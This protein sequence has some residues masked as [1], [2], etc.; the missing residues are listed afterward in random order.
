MLKKTRVQLKKKR[1]DKTRN[2][3]TK[4]KSTS[5]LPITKRK[6]RICRWERSVFQESLKL[7]RQGGTRGGKWSSQEQDAG[8]GGFT[9]QRILQDKNKR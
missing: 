2:K 3:V 7:R 5:G 4:K 1:D 6:P 8:I 9:S